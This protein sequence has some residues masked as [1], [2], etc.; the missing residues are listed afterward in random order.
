ML[1]GVELKCHKGNRKNSET[2]GVKGLDQQ[3][4]FILL[5]GGYKVCPPWGYPFVTLMSI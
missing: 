2:G 1:P 4:V 5:I 3:L